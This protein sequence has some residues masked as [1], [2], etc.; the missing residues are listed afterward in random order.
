[1]ML[2]LTDGE[3]AEVLREAYKKHAEELRAIE[4]SEL[5]LTGIQLGIFGAGASF[6]AAMKQSLPPNAK[7][8]LTVVAAAIILVGATSAFFR[9]R[10]RQQT[11]DLLIRCE[12]A[13]GFQDLDAYLPGEKLYGDVFAKY[14][15]KGWWLALVNGFVASSGVGLILLVWLFKPAP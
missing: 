11:R 4:D 14:P 6:L 3:K 9:N 15:S 5:K 10:A 2:K 12:K 13:L 7:W 8:G 1:M